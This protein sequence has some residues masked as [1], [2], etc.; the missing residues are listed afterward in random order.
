MK[1][2]NIEEIKTILPHR[3]HF[4]LIDKVK[5]KQSDSIL[6]LTVN[7]DGYDLGA[8]RREIDK[9]DLPEILDIVK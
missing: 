7:N 6:F 8:Q 5:A 4:L 9:N 2:I 1:N 3:Y